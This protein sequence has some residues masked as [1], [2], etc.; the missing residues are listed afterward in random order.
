MCNE[1][2]RRR[3]GHENCKGGSAHTA[4]GGRVVEEEVVVVMV[5]GDNDIV[6]VSH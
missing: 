4:V 6:C 3:G 5:R 1:A 2:N